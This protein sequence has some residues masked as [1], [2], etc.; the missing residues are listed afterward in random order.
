MNVSIIYDIEKY[1]KNHSPYYINDDYISIN[2]DRYGRI[3]SF[4]LYNK[5]N[6]IFVDF[7]ETLRSSPY[8]LSNNKTTIIKSFDDFKE[9]WYDY[10]NNLR[11]KF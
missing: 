3:V 4:K 6:N 7:K 8:I 2:D 1:Y 9:K 5:D 10:Y 11:I